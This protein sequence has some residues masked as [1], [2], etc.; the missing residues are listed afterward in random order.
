MLRVGNSYAYTPT[1]MPP[2]A[3]I[4]MVDDEE[5]TR[6]AVVILPSSGSTPINRTPELVVP[7][8]PPSSSLLNHHL[9]L[10]PEGQGPLY[11][12]NCTTPGLYAG[13]LRLT[14]MLRVLKH[15]YVVITIL[16]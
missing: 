6:L 3:M 13:I 15:M 14:L 4:L 1:A 16:N 11:L 9:M 5:R 8:A 12:A 2:T 7:D 10:P